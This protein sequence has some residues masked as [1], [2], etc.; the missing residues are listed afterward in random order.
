M[1]D[2]DL[3]ST[4]GLTP[5][6]VDGTLAVPTGEAAEPFVDAG[7]LADVAVAALTDGRHSG[8]IYEVSGPRMLRFA[9]AAEEISRP[10]GRPVHFVPISERDFADGM[11]AAGV[12]GALL[13]VL[14]EV[15]AELRDGRNATTA[16]GVRRALGRP[17][18]D[19]V[20]YARDAAAAEAWS[21]PA[22]V[23]PRAATPPPTSPAR[24]PGLR[25]TGRTRVGDGSART[26][27]RHHL[28]RRGREQDCSTAGTE[29]GG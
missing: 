2:S 3:A 4:N 15:F 5:M 9:D 23:R 1:Q 19:F 21:I 25:S 11:A 24:R 26:R 13:T 28:D 6:I 10:T 27:H 16:D 17:A 8:E 18:R 20:E 14:S 22:G 29:D 7:D 12:P